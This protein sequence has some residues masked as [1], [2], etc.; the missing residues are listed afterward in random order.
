MAQVAILVRITPEDIERVDQLL[1]KIKQE[2]RPISIGTE[3]VGF[4]IKVIKAL[5]YEDEDKGSAE[6]EDRLSK[7]ENVSSI[8]VLGVDRI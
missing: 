5:F 2:F 8:E 1:N 6:L 4:G 7:V 3:D